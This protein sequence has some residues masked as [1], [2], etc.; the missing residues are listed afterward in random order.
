MKY[1]EPYQS[2]SLFGAL[3]YFS[4][5]KKSVCLINGPSG[6]TFYANN[7]VV[8]LNGY[9]NAQYRV[10]IPRIY[11][12]DFNEHDA[13]IGCDDKVE[14][15]AVEIIEEFHPE[16]LFIFNCCVSEIIGSDIDMIAENVE[17]EYACRVIPVHTAGFKGDHKYGMRMAGDI[18]MTRLFGDK[19]ECK[20]GKVNLLGEFDYFNRSTQELSAFLSRI[21]INDITHVP[22]K[23]SLVELKEAPTAELNI[24][25]CQ[26]ASRYLAE[27]MK[28]KYGIPYIGNG[29]DLYGMENVYNLYSKICDFFDVNKTGLE[30]EYN[31]CLSIV[32]ERKTT[33]QGKSAVIVAST[34][35]ALGYSAILKELG[36]EVSLIF[37]EADEKYTSKKDFLQF[38]HN[39]MFNEFP[40][41][42]VEKI[43]EINPDFIFS[44]LPE[45]VAPHKY[46]VRPEVDYSGF[47]GV[48]RMADYLIELLRQKEK[49]IV[50]EN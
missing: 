15:A 32:Q 27:Q 16:I 18:L 13:I 22:G 11:C 9:F 44:T 34:R 50:I 49:T 43:D 29:S 42:L 4:N 7:A 26:N 3:R 6:C 45:I 38:S 21:G 47:T 25:T 12:T 40:N 2:C 31:S 30:K 28:K 14:Q 20:K 24:I 35:R 46:L 5:L 8:R 39:V 36:I 19:Q 10:D 37:S 23:C 41:T 17:R 48:I 33:L 1:C